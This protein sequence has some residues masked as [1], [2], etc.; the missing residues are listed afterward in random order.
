MK[1]GQNINHNTQLLTQQA[2][3]FSLDM[4]YLGSFQAELSP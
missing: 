3:E 1:T 2:K 4:Y